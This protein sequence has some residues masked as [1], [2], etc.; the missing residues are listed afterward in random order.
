MHESTCLSS[1]VEIA[2]GV[3]LLTGAFEGFRGYLVRSLKA[4]NQRRI[5]TIKTLE[6]EEE[7]AR[8]HLPVFVADMESVNEQYDYMQSRVC[9]YARTVAIA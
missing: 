1:F 9:L 7:K 4:R 2:F 6:V 3:N 8:R 5:S